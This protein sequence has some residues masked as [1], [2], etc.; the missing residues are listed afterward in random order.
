MVNY[1]SSLDSLANPTS[2]T[3]CDD[4]GFELDVVISNLNDIAEALEAKLGIGATT[5]NAQ[6]KTLGATAAGTSAWG[7]YGVRLLGTVSAS[8]SSSVMEIASISGSFSQLL[9]MIWGKSTTAGTGG[10]ACR[11]TFE[12]SPTAGA[13]NHQ[14]LLVNNT[15]VT[16]IQNVG[17]NDWI[18][19]GLF[20]SDGAH[21]SLFG[22]S[23]VT[24]MDYAGS[25]YKN[26]FSLNCGQN[27]ISSGGL[28]MR[29]V[30][31]LYESTSAIDRIRVTASTGN[32]KSG[33]KMCVYG[34]PNA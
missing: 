1:P 17:T 23:W 2:T 29:N 6:Y 20:P 24:I 28:H 18:D 21:A 3:D 31:G 25:A 34:V 14:M 5:P 7:Y 10:A 26:V 8:G 12:T 11:M 9:V 15:S 4:A 13:Y 22:S 33:S 19:A 27:D 32:W 30:S 16:A